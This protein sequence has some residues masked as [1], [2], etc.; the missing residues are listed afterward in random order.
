MSQP[1]ELPESVRD[2]MAA[3]FAGFK[4]QAKPYLLSYGAGG[5]SKE[6]LWYTLPVSGYAPFVPATSP[7]HSPYTTS[8]NTG[9]A[10]DNPPANVGTFPFHPNITR[11][12]RNGIATYVVSIP[13]NVPALSN[14]LPDLTQKVVNAFTFNAGTQSSSTYTWQNWVNDV[15]LA[16]SRFQQ[17]ASADVQATFLGAPYAAKD[18]TSSLGAPMPPSILTSAGTYIWSAYDTTQP[19]PTGNGINEIILTDQPIGGLGFTSML[20]DPANGEIIECD[21]LFNVAATAANGGVFG[22]IRPVGGG[23]SAPGEWTAL[24]HELGHFWGL[25]HTNLHP[26]SGLAAL[27]SVTGASLSS[28]PAAPAP[29]GPSEIPGMAGAITYMG[30]GYNLLGQALHPDDATALSRIYPVRLPDSSRGK[31]PLI[32]LTATM[33]GRFQ[34]VNGNGVFGKNILAVPALTVGTVGATY[35]QRGILSGM[36]RLDM[37][38]LLTTPNPYVDTRPGMN[39][40]LY[41]PG[42]SVVGMAGGTGGFS[43]QGLI[44]GGAFDATTG[45]PLAYDLIMEESGIS[46][47]RNG[48]GSQSEWFNDGVFY[49]GNTPTT[50]NLPSENGVLVH[51]STYTTSGLQSGPVSLLPGETITSLSVVAGTV[52]DLHPSDTNDGVIAGTTYTT[53]GSSPSFTT[54]PAVRE[55]AF[56][57]LV[58]IDPRF[59]RA[60][61]QNVTI[62]ARCDRANLDMTL[63]TGVRLYVN[64]VDKTTAILSSYPPTVFPSGSPNPSYA[65]WT[66]PMTAIVGSTPQDE[67]VR[68]TFLAKVLTSQAFDLIDGT[69]II[70][71][72]GRNDVVL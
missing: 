3:L 46:R 66:I 11:H 41:Y 25:D 29:A 30:L 33:R 45:T 21:I 59:G 17:V 23:V 9:L 32:N 28:F 40:A 57:P 72:W 16:M 37:D 35:A 42:S 48:T 51:S 50:A 54:A 69:A 52:I 27:N 24:P 7:L 26:G 4:K 44:V 67:P 47:L 14:G 38:P 20:V 43:I 39:A 2:P 36:D 34:D 71:A 1:S 31:Y 5:C 18:Y 60:R 8:A 58:S 6:V 56:R 63:G 13:R 49:A 55:Q 68:V 10:G 22:L 53:A 64:G 70:A 19:G 15:Q 65:Q 61:A 12:W 62:R